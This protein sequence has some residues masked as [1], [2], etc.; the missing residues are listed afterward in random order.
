[1]EPDNK[2]DLLSKDLIGFYKNG[3]VQRIIEDGAEV[4]VNRIE[5]YTVEGELS[6]LNLEEE[7]S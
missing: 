6:Q 1:L 4:V 5:P 3:Q 7:F 2:I